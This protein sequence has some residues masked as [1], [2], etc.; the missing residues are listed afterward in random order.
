MYAFTSI[1]SPKFLN[2]RSLFLQSALLIGVARAA[3][4]DLKFRIYVPEQGGVLT[5]QT[6]WKA[7]PELYL[8]ENG[9]YRRLAAARGQASRFFSYKGEAEMMLFTREVEQ[10]RL[11]LENPDPDEEAPLREFSTYKPHARVLFPEGWT[12][13]VVMIRPEERNAEGL[14]WAVAMNIDPSR[15]PKGKGTFYNASGRKLALTVGGKAHMIRS[16]QRLVLNRAQVQEKE[17]GEMAVGRMVLAE[18]DKDGGSWKPRYT[19]PV[20]LKPGV[21]NLFLISDSG[22]DRV[23]VRAVYGE[24]ESS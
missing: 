11:E 9:N 21:S 14:C 13:A 1:F 20:Y 10:R 19:R 8:Q 18:Q 5:E 23:R 4:V 2:L 7:L 24:E 17:V 16:G 6:I 15:L 22:N 3:E 12:E